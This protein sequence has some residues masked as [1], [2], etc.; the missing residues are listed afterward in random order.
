MKYTFEVEYADE[1]GEDW[2]GLGMVK[3]CLTSTVH[4]G[5]G[6]LVAVEDVTGKNM[7]TQDYFEQGI[8][9]DAK[10]AGIETEGIVGM[11]I[12]HMMAER[13]IDLAR[14]YED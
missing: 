13:I 11:A 4:I 8:E 5:L 2:M 7:K 12:V 6:S 9:D 10:R 1:L 14:S 3:D